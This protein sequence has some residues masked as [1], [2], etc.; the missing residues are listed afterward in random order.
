LVLEGAPHDYRVT[1]VL[2]DPPAATDLEFDFMVPFTPALTAGE[3]YWRHWGS[4]Q[5]DTYLRFKTPAAAHAI[6]ADLDHFVDRHAGPDLPRQTPHASMGLPLRSLLSLHLLN[7]KDAAVVAALGAV[8]VLVAIMAAINHINLATVGASLR[9]RE[10]ALRKVM[11]STRQ[12]LMAQFMG[13]AVATVALAALLALGLC[14]LALP[15]IN[16]MSGLSLRLDYGALDGVL[17][18][19]LVVVVL[20]SLCAG[21]YPALVLSSFQPAAVLASARAPGGGRASGRVRQGL[22]VFQF[23]IAIAFTIS[24]AVIVA[25]TH[26]IRDAD[27]GFQRQGLIIVNSFDD[28]SV[29][30]AERSSLLA[31]W[32]G[33]PGVQGATAGDIAPGDD[34]SSSA[35][36][37]KR[38]GAV[39]DGI[40]IHYV[41]TRP[42]FLRVYGARLLAGRLLDQ[43]H[44]GDDLQPRSS[45]TG[46]QPAPAN[47]VL[48]IKAVET[49]GFRNARAALGQSLTDGYR[50]FVVVGVIDNIRFRNPREPIPATI[51]T[52]T[53]HNF[54][55]M[56][57]GVRYSAAKPDAV[58][59]SL[60][61]T[62]RQIAPDTP[63]RAKTSAENLQRYYD[64]AER[65][66]RL[67]TLGAA[68]TVLIGC[69][70]LYGLAAF[71]TARRYK[72]IGIRKTLGASTGE[73]L[74]L[75]LMQVLRPVAAANLIAWPL[76]YFAMRGWLSGFDQRIG[77]SP[78]YFVA[79]TVLALAVAALT[80]LAQSLRLARAE[81]A[82]ALRHE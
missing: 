23:A 37:T 31:A 45:A 55:A 40:S 34:E 11:G 27:L 1:G 52:Q 80:V 41:R 60:E 24:T 32:R 51:Y 20:I 78:L 74:R 38:V 6:A 69:L 79:A 15:A 13:E 25:E 61:R 56:A 7:P 76:A 8:G 9:A 39:G 14:E 16:A 67:F 70:G 33:L 2:A 28:D 17:P 10:V 42:D 18:L 77:L 21:I 46:S 54:E 48:N 30:P 3:T 62:W 82:R 81:P 73:V 50:R 44:G 43:S 36:S 57:A 75:L 49:L 22:V 59:A 68:L 72:E 4:A 64:D 63:F 19:L 26:F 12:A 66:G 35:T 53:T 71:N 5:L 58:M 29:T 65:Q 47:V